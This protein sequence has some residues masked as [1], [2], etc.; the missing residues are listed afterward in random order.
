MGGASIKLNSVSY[1]MSPSITSDVASVCIITMT[2]NA[3]VSVRSAPGS[4]VLLKICF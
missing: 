4:A 2:Y 3:Y 1:E